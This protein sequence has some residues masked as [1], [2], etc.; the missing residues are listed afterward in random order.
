MKLENLRDNGSFARNTW[1]QIKRLI[2]KKKIDFLLDFVLCPTF[3]YSSELVLDTYES[4][5]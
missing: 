2:L 1:F 5:T 4:G 3:V